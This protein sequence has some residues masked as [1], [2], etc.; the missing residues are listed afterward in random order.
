MVW[1]PVLASDWDGPSAATLLRIPDPRASHFWD[2]DRLIS[3]AMGEHDR[4]S[5]VWD[6]IAVYPRGPRW[7]DRPPDAIYHGRP[8]ADVTE[9]TT[10]ALARALGR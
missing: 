8:V 5:I 3:H 7:T 2:H 4:E 6:Y 1:E 10:A 9:P